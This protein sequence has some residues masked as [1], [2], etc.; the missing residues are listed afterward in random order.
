ME[1][2]S[3]QGDVSSVEMML[4]EMMLIEMMLIEMMLILTHE[5]LKLK[6]IL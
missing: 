6:E 5:I 3:N 1:T 4:I 2:P